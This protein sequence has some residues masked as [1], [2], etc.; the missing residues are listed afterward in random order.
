MFNKLTGMTGV[1]LWWARGGATGDV[2]GQTESLSRVEQ[3]KQHP[4]DF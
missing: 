2:D 3:T 1:V 4:P